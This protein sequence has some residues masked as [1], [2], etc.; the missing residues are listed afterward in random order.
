MTETTRH[1][2]DER[3]LPAVFAA[4]KRRFGIDA[5]ALAAFRVSLGLLILG[6]LAI[7]SRDLVA[8][9][10]D[11]GVLPRSALAE[12]YPTLASLSL[13]ALSGGAWTQVLLFCVAAGLAIALTV[14]YRTRVATLGSVFLLGS[15]YARNPYVLNGGN[16]LLFV[17]VLC[18]LFVPLGERWSVD[19]RRHDGGSAPGERPNH[20]VVSLATATL[21]VQLVGIYLANAA[22]KLRS[23]RW[24]D[25]VAVRYVFELDAFTVGFGSSL[26]SY[27]TL[28]VAVNW[29]WIAMLVA[30]P[31]LLLSTGRRRA[32]AVSAFVAAHLGMALTM[33]LGLFPLVVIAGLVCYL[34]PAVWDTVERTVNRLPV[35]GR[36]RLGAFAPRIQ[37]MSTLSPTVSRSRLALSPTVRRRI[38]R[39]GT[40][41]VTVVLCL[42]LAWHAA[43][44]AGLDVDGEAV[45]AVDDDVASPEGAYVW[46]LFAPNPPSSSGWYVTPAELASGEQVDAFHGGDVEW[47]RPPDIADAYP[48][49][50]WHRY[51]GALKHGT[52]AEH[53]AFAE[54]LCTQASIAH[55]ESVESVTISRVEETVRLDASNS[56]ERR[57]LFEHDCASG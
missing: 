3:P 28:L 7:R 29:A 4:I 21:L 36:L 5:R 32:A 35:G 42:S 16:A 47:E 15:L 39:G 23:E 57:T 40:A 6:D 45:P 37:P 38:R 48:T 20:H 52:E 13:H 44:A 12:T 27:P 9:Y 51:L 53:R 14:G 22:F 26:G 43:A 19:A 33:R 24:T 11:A 56:L 55:G 8:F 50:L 17:F 30:A 10:T 1:G 54:Y 18:G 46:R 31:L 25:G 49:A 41:A 2:G 34:P